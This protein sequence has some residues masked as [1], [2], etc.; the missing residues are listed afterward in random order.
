MS[1]PNIFF[2]QSI[3]FDAVV[4]SVTSNNYIAA[5]SM[6]K[7]AFLNTVVVQYLQCISFKLHVKTKYDRLTSIQ[8]PYLELYPQMKCNLLP[9]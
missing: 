2:Y 6:L 4:L 1:V 7:H 5:T 8:T 9:F 3:A